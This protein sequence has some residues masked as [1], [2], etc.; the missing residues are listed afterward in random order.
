MLVMVMVMATVDRA[1]HGSQCVQH[2]CIS[3]SLM[4]CIA[5]TPILEETVGTFLLSFKARKT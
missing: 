2:Y 3:F 1:S 4:F 5:F